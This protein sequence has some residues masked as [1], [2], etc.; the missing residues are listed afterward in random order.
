MGQ[1]TRR[2]EGRIYLTDM[3][4]QQVFGVFVTPTCAAIN[5]R[6]YE[7]VLAGRWDGTRVVPIDAL[8]KPS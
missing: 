5:G 1:F 6:L 7:M 8:G 3:H 2:D 4:Q